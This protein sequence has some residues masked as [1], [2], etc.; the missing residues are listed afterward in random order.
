MSERLVVAEGL[1]NLINGVV[2]VLK[3]GLF[4]DVIGLN[5]DNPLD[6]V[7]E[8]I[9]DED[10]DWPAGGDHRQPAD[11]V[12]HQPASCATARCRR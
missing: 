10:V 4:G 8:P 5:A 1:D 9:K 11:S 12:Y 7:H 2:R 6:P 3:I